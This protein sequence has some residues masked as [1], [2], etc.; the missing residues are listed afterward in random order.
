MVEGFKNT[1][2][3]VIPEDWNMK[4]LGE[5]GEVRMCRR[6]FNHETKVQGEIPFSRLE[7]SVKNLMPT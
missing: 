5:V 7:L 6:V 4:T 1:E 3:G 2:V